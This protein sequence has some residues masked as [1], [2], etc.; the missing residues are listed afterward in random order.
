M[1]ILI[2]CCAHIIL[3]V[4]F[5][6][7]KFKPLGVLTYAQFLC[8][9]AMCDE[10]IRMVAQPWSSTSVLCVNRLTVNFMLWPPYPVD[11]ISEPIIFTKT[12]MSTYLQELGDSVISAVTGQEMMHKIQ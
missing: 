7:Y 11:G 12:L 2:K 9:K 1:Y 8:V 6:I 10:A 5:G 3:K 4:L